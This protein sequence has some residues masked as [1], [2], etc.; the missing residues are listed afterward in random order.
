M[1]DIDDLFRNLDTDTDEEQTGVSG[2]AVDGVANIDP[3]GAAEKL[4]KDY[5]RYL[6]TLLNPRDPEIATS[7]F[8]AVDSSPSLA[9][10][11]I[12]Q[13]TAP[14]APGAT[15]R[16]LID[17]GVLGADFAA[18]DATVPLDRPLYLH[19]EEAIRKLKNGRNLVVSTGTGSGKT[20]SFL[21]PIV[22]ELL[23]EHRAGTLG[24]GVRAL[25]LYPMNALAN[26]QMKRLREML[27]DAP[28][29]TFGRYTGETEE[30]TKAATALYRDLNDH[31]DPLVNELVSREQIRANPP[32]ILLTNYAM[33][34][35]LLL[36]PE[37]N[38]LFDGATAGKWRFIV[39]DEAHVYAGAKGTEIGMLLRRLKDR[40][41]R[42]SDLQCIATSASLEGAPDDVMRFAESLFDSPFEYD[43]D[44][45]SRRDLVNST[46]LASADAYDWAL[47][48]SEFDAGIGAASLLERVHAHVGVEP[49]A[50]LPH[51]AIDSVADA[52]A[53]EEHVFRLRSLVSGGSRSLSDLG[54]RM[55]PGMDLAQSMHRVHQ[56]V[57]LGGRVLD[58]A[59]RPV[60][61]ARYHM[62]IRATEGAF[63]G[64]DG[65]G[66]PS[67]TLERKVTQDGDDAR[68]PV[69]EF[70]TCVHCGAVHLLG[71]IG[72]PERKD[73]VGTFYPTSAADAKDDVAWLVITDGGDAAEIDDDDQTERA[74][75]DEN[76]A[77]ISAS[78][79]LTL[80]TGCGRIRAGHARECDEPGCAGARQV[81][82]RRLGAPGA[83]N[84]TCHECG[85]SSPN[86]VR[87]LLTDANA[88][89]SVLTTSLFQQLPGPGE[90]GAG[91]SARRKLLTF[92]DSR[93]AAAFAAPYLENTYGKLL[94]NR[95]LHEALDSAAFGGRGSL[96]FW[97]ER[98]AAIAAKHGVIAGR[99]EEENKSAVGA[100]AFSS[101]TSVQRR[102]SLEGL[103]LARFGLS[104]EAF[105]GLGKLLGA[106]TGI[107][108]DEHMAR[109]FIDVLVSDV[110]LRGA[111][112]MPD[113]VDPNDDHFQPRAG[114]WGIRDAGGGDP[115]QRLYS[116]LPADG[117]A[118][119]RTDYV[120]K[121]LAASSFDIPAEKM[122]DQVRYL[123]RQV[124]KFLEKS[125]ILQASA[126]NRASYGIN[127]SA[128][129]VRSGA[130]ATWH[131]CDTCRTITAFNVLGVC[132][133]RSCD[134]EL[135][136][137]DSD[138]PGYRDN[139]YRV[140]ST[141]MEITPLKAMEHT[142][143]WE[144]RRAGQIQR[145]FIDGTINVLS[146]STTFELGVDVGDLQAVIL[147]NT[148][149]R[150]ANYVQRAGRAGRRA[151]SAAFVLT[152]AKR[153]AHD[154]SVYKD[155]I[156]MIDGIMQTPYVTIDNERIAT[157]HAY[158]VAFAEFLRAETAD[159]PGWKKVGGFFLPEQPDKRAAERLRRFLTPVPPR[160]TEALRRILPESVRDAIGVD[161]A[162]WA[163]GYLDLMDTV[164]ESNLADQKTL[165]ELATVHSEMKKFTEAARFQR[166]LT[167]M[168][169]EQTLGH[170]AAKNL[171]PKY[172][173][174]VD[175]VEMD[176]RHT[177]VG[178]S[179]RLSRD[180]SLA[181]T[182]YAPGAKVVAGNAQWESKGVRLMPGKDLPLYELKECHRCGQATARRHTM[183]GIEACDHCSSP[184][185]GKPVSMVLPVFGFVAGSVP[186]KVGEIPPKTPWYRKDY[187]LNDGDAVIGPKVFGTVQGGIEVAASARAQICVVNGGPSNYGYFLCERCGFAAPPGDVTSIAHK[188]PRTGRDC[189]ARLQMRALGH[190]Y[191]TDIASI[192]L[193][194]SFADRNDDVRGA[195]YAIVESASELLEIN[196]DDINGTLSWSNQGPSL[197]LF[198]AVPGG[199]GISRQIVGAFRGVLEKAIAR[200]ADCGCDIDTSCYSCLRSYSNQRYH[201]DL[202]RLGA[203][204]ALTGIREIVMS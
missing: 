135:Q 170:L 62:F 155:P 188:N 126:L 61:S 110:R 142:A 153:S 176:T 80:C 115:K 60:L 195:L 39:L 30:S 103:G 57:D 38:E 95:I 23:R 25:L 18:L 100:W 140:L 139:H 168:M 27:R 187:V 169:D 177:D 185:A 124:W 105:A 116:W 93:Q 198:D 99:T 26:D 78:A 10:G 143:Q 194:P 46:P 190:V 184:L 36:R 75:R 56:L 106:L 186:G 178:A 74:A 117:R 157:R 101:A 20:E 59:H 2:I 29:I 202:T 200:V 76:T 97:V 81:R 84:E 171:L 197:V 3:I 172:G 165:N 54:R 128:I 149:P 151:G 107:V 147:R 8:D 189:S 15:A 121:V 183:E 7:Y 193:P 72:P 154:M 5:R 130:S 90:S 122:P 68:R 182:D 22:D 42:G 79:L 159:W 17:E 144:P 152:F 179:I 21:L 201:D 96:D 67:V 43:D 11:P 111:L 163:D 108:G 9:K 191:Q 63:V 28:E 199:A 112:R 65:E 24:A 1:N 109:D 16:E 156:A 51:S 14:Y 37:D 203:L 125:E 83:A 132:P 181:I 6:K 50:D 129:E 167:T 32:H 102:Q 58:S 71:L 164:Q 166:T 35:Y 146:C 91:A 47:D 158:S 175:S 150:T 92:S 49:G 70:G 19:Q 127:P 41:S 48:D 98:T 40:V 66:N 133:T 64:Y 161:D 88:A 162:R 34:E 113:Y 141:S 114:V 131:V 45:P 12:L 89:P 192:H 73:D 87:R 85:R 4:Q 196:R 174:P 145:E 44:D 148:P 52:L 104:D 120:A 94:E 13:L 136:L 53:R 77:P 119:N 33:L 31:E 86:L 82:V 123:L 160:I 137:L 204:E 118:N 173:F 180:L 69:Y 138:E 55:W 134:G